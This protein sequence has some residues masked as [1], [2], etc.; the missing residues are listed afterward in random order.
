MDLNFGFSSCYVNRR[1]YATINYNGACVKCTNN[2][3]LYT[4][5]TYGKINSEGK[6]EWN[7]A[8]EEHNLAPSF[9]RPECLSC[10]ILPLCMGHCPQNMSDS[11]EWR[12]KIAGQDI[13]IKRSIIS[14]IEY[15]EGLCKSDP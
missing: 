3:S 9:E 1:Y 15:I 5:K 14:H 7:K 13:D 11:K 10:N 12:C 8:Y 6:I 4:G 2:D